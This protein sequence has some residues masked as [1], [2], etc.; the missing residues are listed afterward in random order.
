MRLRVL[1]RDL[2]IATQEPRQTSIQNVLSAQ[3]LEWTADAHPSQVLVRLQC[4][5]EVLIARITARAMHNLG[6][7]QGQAVWL[8]V[9]SVALVG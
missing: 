3:V 7:Q 1:A 2:S 6:L 8:Q 9:K 5:T 4:G